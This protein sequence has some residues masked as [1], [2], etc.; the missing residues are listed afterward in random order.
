M[1]EWSTGRLRDR[2][3]FDGTVRSLSRRYQTDPESPFNR[4]LKHTTREKD[5]HVLTLIGKAF[6][7]RTLPSLKLADFWRWYDA[8][9]KPKAPGKPQRVRR[10]WGIMKKLREL[11]S[12][13]VAAELAGCVR[14]RDILAEVRFPQPAWRRVTL[15]LEHVE[16][17][18]PKRS[19][20][21]ASP[22]HSPPR[23]S[24]TR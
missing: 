6:G 13:G 2:N 7:D 8:A 1:L 18:I 23:S 24:S 3:R 10:A 22:W 19:R 4:R 17:F 20:W 21:G 12:Y 11:F 14:V 15:D 16:A 9:K 5:T